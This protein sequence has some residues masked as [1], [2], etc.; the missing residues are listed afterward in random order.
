MADSELWSY[1]AVNWNYVDDVTGGWVNSNTSFDAKSVFT[2]YSNLN[3]NMTADSAYIVLSQ[4]L[5]GAPGV[6]ASASATYD[7]AAGMIAELEANV[8]YQSKL[9]FGFNTN[10]DLQLDTIDNTTPIPSVAPTMAPSVAP[11]IA[12]SGSPSL[13]PS[14]PPSESPTV[15]PTLLPGET[16]AP[17]EAPSIA[18][19]QPTYAPSVSPSV[20]PSMMPSQLP[21]VS[22]TLLPSGVP[23]VTLTP[24][25]LPSRAPS[26]TP[27]MAP[28]NAAVQFAASQVDLFIFVDVEPMKLIVFCL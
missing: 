11:T 10:Y 21:S 4:T 8:N 16:Y 3:V 15:V 1:N 14:A 7:M 5:N 9:L 6:L 19:S 13:A 27:T 20:A 28:T 18:P 25:A 26:V 17:T 24:S 2:L 23:S 12:P 22:P